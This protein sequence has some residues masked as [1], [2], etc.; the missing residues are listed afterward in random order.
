MSV[1]ARIDGARCN[2]DDNAQDEIQQSH[3][4]ATFHRMTVTLQLLRYSKSQVFCWAA[5][6]AEPDVPLP[7]DS[8]HQG[9]MQF[10]SSASITPSFEE[11]TADELCSIHCNLTLSVTR[12]ACAGEYSKNFSSRSID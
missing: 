10:I 8:P 9:A 11:S 6:L 5:E 1:L 2:R 4:F 7:A 12:V 3:C